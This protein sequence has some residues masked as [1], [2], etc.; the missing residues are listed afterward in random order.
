MRRCS[1][2]IYKFLKT[3]IVIPRSIDRREMTTRDLYLREYC[4]IVFKCFIDQGSIVSLRYLRAPRDD[5]HKNMI[6]L[7]IDPGTARI[8]IGIIKKTKTNPEYI[9]HDCIETDKLLDNSARLGIIHKEIKKLIEKYSPERAA[10][11]ELF[12]FKNAKTAITVGQARGVIL[13]AIQQAGI[14]LFEFTP[15]QVKQSVV[16]YGK[17]EKKQVQL[18]VKTILQMKE[19]PRPDDAAD[20]LAIALC[21]ERA[22]FPLL[23]GR[24]TAKK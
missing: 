13:L 5:T 22:S 12:F 19:I 16:G 2:N 14:P 20:A 7:G 17:A 9:H 1:R 6:I 15:L 8:G 4:N 23:K 11:E 10:V 3:F 24:E 21:A 18:M